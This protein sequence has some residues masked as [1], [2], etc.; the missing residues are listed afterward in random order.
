[1]N[2]PTKPCGARTKNGHFCRLPAGPN[3]RCRFHGGASTGPRTADGR[4]ACA[5]AATKHGIYASGYT[6]EEL[7]Q[8]DVLRD[9]DLTA[10]ITLARVILMRLLKAAPDPIGEGDPSDHSDEYWWG[11]IDRFL[12]RIGRLVEQRARVEEVR[13]LQKQLEELKARLPALSRT[14]AGASPPGGGH[15]QASAKSPTTPYWSSR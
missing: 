11:L 1:M 14:V 7:R 15:P 12:G 4:R 13:E 10:E 6:E 2:E 9:T 5:L 8:L 3:S